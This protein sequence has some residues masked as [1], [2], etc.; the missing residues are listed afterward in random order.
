M[1]DDP[2]SLLNLWERAR[3]AHNDAARR[4]DYKAAHAL[5]AE[6]FRLEGR[7]RWLVDIEDVVAILR[8][9]EYG[10]DQ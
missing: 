5:L 8:G 10:V 3:A 7:L 4:G 6:Q 1:N 9:Q 2:L